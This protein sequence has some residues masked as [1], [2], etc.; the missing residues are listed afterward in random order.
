MTDPRNCARGLTGASGSFQFTG[1]NAGSFARNF[2]AAVEQR[3][4]YG[5]TLRMGSDGQAFAGISRVRSQAVCFLGHVLYWRNPTFKLE[6]TSP[7][8]AWWVS[9]GCPPELVD[10]KG[11]PSPAERPFFIRGGQQP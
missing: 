3:G 2:V 10:L 7:T 4:R 6:C 5:E 11:L 9:R 1:R 8:R